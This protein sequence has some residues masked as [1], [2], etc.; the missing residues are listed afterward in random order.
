MKFPGIYYSLIRVL[1][2]RTGLEPAT[3]AVTGQHSNQLNYRSIL[4]RI[5][6]GCFINHRKYSLLQ[7][8]ILFSSIKA[9]LFNSKARTNINFHGIFDLVNRLSPL[10]CSANRL[11]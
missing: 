11:R 10:L 8:L 3:S 4:V 9:S 7:R 5:F 6:T 2:D 1:A